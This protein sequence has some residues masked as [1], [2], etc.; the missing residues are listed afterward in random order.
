[1]RTLPSTIT[2]TLHGNDDTAPSLCYCDVI[3]ENDDLKEPSINF[4]EVA[5][6]FNQSVNVIG[7]MFRA[8]VGNAAGI[9]EAAASLLADSSVAADATVETP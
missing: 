5:P 1:M 4:E 8:A 2:L 3:V 9:E 7:P 6:D